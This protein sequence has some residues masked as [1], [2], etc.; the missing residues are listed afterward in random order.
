MI[1]TFR[2]LVVHGSISPAV[3]I[4]RVGVETEK[5]NWKWKER[6]ECHDGNRKW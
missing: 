5:R 6:K 1:A 2:D 3:S 4:H